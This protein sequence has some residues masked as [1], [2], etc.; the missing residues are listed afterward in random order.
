[1]CWWEDDGQD[2]ADADIARGGP[3]SNLSLTQARV[4]FLLFGIADPRESALLQ[5]E[6]GRPYEVK[7]S[8][9]LAADRSTITE[10]AAGWQSRAFV[11]DP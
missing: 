8:F 11:V 9:V 6:P 1:M 2:N 5:Q 4:N 3:N 7:R 10:P